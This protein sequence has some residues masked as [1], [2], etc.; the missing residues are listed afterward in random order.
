[1]PTQDHDPNGQAEASAERSRV[2]KPGVGRWFGPLSQGVK[3]LVGIIIVALVGAVVTAVVANWFGP[4]ELS[5]RLS[6]VSIDRGI[7]L[8]EFEQRQRK[9]SASV[10]R[11]AVVVRVAARAMAQATP[12]ETGS[13]EESVSPGP[14]T[15][16]PTPTTP[17]PTITT[18]EPTTTAG[19]SA[20]VK[21][22]LSPVARQRLETGVRRALTDS[23]VPELDLP[24]TCTQDVSSPNCGL[25]SLQR[26]LQLVKKDGTPGTVRPEVIARRLVKIFRG[27]RTQRAPSGQGKR[28]PVGVIVN[29]NASL[30]GFRGKRADIRWSLYNAKRGIRVPQDWLRN[31]H[32]LSLEGKADK[33]NRS[34]E[35]WV[36]VPKAKGPY[37]VRFGVYDADDSR[38]DYANTPPFR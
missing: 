13:P 26:Q 38:L 4:G 21:L 15:P 8:H 9:D 7:T 2:P 3:W 22:K 32:A 25:S 12:E 5:A 35:F 27:T 18:P 19:G 33:D 28:Q 16:D 24:P 1:M 17:E 29:F 6:Q 31:Q 23:R 37:Y 11:L 36:P 20:V 34:R 10:P 14:A 30:T